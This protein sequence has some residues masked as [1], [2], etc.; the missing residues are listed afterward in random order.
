MLASDVG[1]GVLNAFFDGSQDGSAIGSLH[2]DVG[3][4]DAL[5]N[6]AVGPELNAV[7]AVEGAAHG[8]IEVIVGEKRVGSGDLGDFA[9]GLHLECRAG[10]GAVGF[11]EKSGVFANEEAAVADGGESFGSVGDGGVEAIADFADRG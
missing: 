9:I 10:S 11:E 3:F 5:R 6:G 2:R 1:F 4:V 8:V 7:G